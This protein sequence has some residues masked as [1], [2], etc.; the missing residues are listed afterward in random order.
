MNTQETRQVGNTTYEVIRPSHL[1]KKQLIV[2]GHNKAE[3]TKPEHLRL[4]HPMPECITLR[5]LSPKTSVKSLV[6][7]KHNN[8]A[9]FVKE[10]HR[11][12]HFQG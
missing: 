6:K 9:K 2:V 7:A 10:M 3:L 11:H 12:N 8:P 4:M 5:R 1:T